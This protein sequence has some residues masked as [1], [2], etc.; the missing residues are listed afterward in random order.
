MS[1]R[2]LIHIGTSGWYYRHWKGPFYPEGLPDERLPEHYIKHFQTVESNNSFYQLPEKD[3][4][5]QWH[6]DVS[7]LGGFLE[8]LRG[9]HR[10]AFEF[11]AGSGMRPKT[12]YLKKALKLKE[13]IEKK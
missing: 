3:I 9:S 8:A 13:L 4:F 6:I 2:A 12:S 5:M 10:Y 1:K 11:R 7:R